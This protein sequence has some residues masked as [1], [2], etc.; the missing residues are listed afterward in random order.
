MS[1]LSEAMYSE[2]THDQLVDRLD[3]I[4]SEVKGIQ[5]AVAAAIEIDEAELADS[6]SKLSALWKEE[7]LLKQALADFLDKTLPKSPEYIEARAAMDV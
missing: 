2:W 1:V 3:A 7:R 5:D 6:E 4:E